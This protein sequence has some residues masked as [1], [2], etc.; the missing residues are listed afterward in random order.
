MV[1]I[2]PVDPGD[3]TMIRTLLAIAAA[4][5]LAGCLSISSRESPAAAA[6]PAQ[7]CQA[8]EQQCRDTC[9]AAGVQAFTC[10]SKPGGGFE[11]RCECRG[12]AMPS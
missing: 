8:R 9:G 2:N 1:M 4:L 3:Q 6:D 7:A 5:L 10:T 11:Y 12:R